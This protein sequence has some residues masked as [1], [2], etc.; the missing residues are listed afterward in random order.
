MKIEKSGFVYKVAYGLRDE[1]SDIP[2][3]ISLCK[4]FWRFLG[5]L[6][7][8]WPIV[9]TLRLIVTVAAHVFFCVIGFIFFAHRPTI[10]M[11]NSDKGIKTITTEIEHWPEIM[12]R[13]ISP[14]WAILVVCVVVDFSKIK[15]GAL[16]FV[17]DAWNEISSKDAIATFSLIGGMV[18][19]YIIYK[20]VAAI[21]KKIKHSEA[22]E[23][24][25]EFLKAKKQQICPIVE[26]VDDEKG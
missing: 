24:Y 11:L 23:L 3:S 1:N 12:G 25:K 17:A 26:I 19:A 22:L 6:L 4:L 10:T 21:W 16:L 13:R 9:L 15:K 18:I 2:E 8:A 7:L 14:I 5:M 20:I